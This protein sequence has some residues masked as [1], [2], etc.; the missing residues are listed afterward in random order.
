MR[1]VNHALSVYLAASI[2]NNQRRRTKY[3]RHVDIKPMFCKPFINDKFVKTDYFAT[4]DDWRRYEVD[5]EKYIKEWD[6]KWERD[7][8]PAKPD[9]FM[10]VLSIA[11]I[12]IACVLISAVG[13]F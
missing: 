10:T 3:V 8:T 11:G 9:P 5:P 7:H 12:V 6:E 13:Q 2:M 4:E 1:R